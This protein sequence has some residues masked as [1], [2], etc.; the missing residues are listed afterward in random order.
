[1]KQKIAQ[2]RTLATLL[3]PL[4]RMLES[5]T[6]VA[7]RTK[8][9]ESQNAEQREATEAARKLPSQDTS[10]DMSKATSALSNGK[11]SDAMSPN[12]SVTPSMASR[13]SEQAGQTT[14]GQTS[15]S[16]SDAKPENAAQDRTS[17]TTE[18]AHSASASSG[19][20]NNKLVALA[21]K[22]LQAL[23]NMM[24]NA[25]GKETSNGPSIGQSS[26][27]SKSNK[28]D[29][30]GQQGTA[31]AT[32]ASGQ[33]SKGA[34]ENG[35]GMDITSSANHGQLSGAGNSAPA[36]AL[37]ANRDRIN[38][39]NLQLEHVP[40]ESNGFKGPTGKDRANVGSGTAQVP[41]QNVAPPAVATVNGAGQDTVPARYM[42]YV[43]D[44]FDQGK[45]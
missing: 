45:K 38:P 42:Q 37:Q 12:G 35:Q 44:Y 33:A 26:Q 29:S 39:A 13:A 34:S 9:G 22:A 4:S 20:S 11:T 31:Q 43:R 18:S 1:L 19:N 40:L 3:S 7:E 32:A 14:S 5:A 23:E 41:L 2:S 6:S 10:A 21:Q 15:D 30:N 25:L 8:G 16:Q 28:N 27:Q 36:W 24:Q 17:N